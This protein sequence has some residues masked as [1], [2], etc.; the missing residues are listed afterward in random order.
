MLRGQLLIILFLAS[1]LNGLGQNEAN[2]LV[3]WLTIKE[4]QERNKLAPR[5]FLFD[6]YTDWC[7]WCKHMMKTTYSNPAIAEYV[8]QN[9]YP[10][11]F[12]AEG[13]DTIEYNG[14]VYK[15]LSK[16]PKVPHE[17]ALKMLGQQL[18]YPSTVFVT[19]NFEYTLLSQGFLEEKKIEPILVF[20]VENAW[21]TV[22][23]EEFNTNFTRT[24]Y[25]T[26]F[27]KKPVKIYAMKDLEKLQKKKPK[28]VLVSVTSS[29]CNSCKVMGKTT[30]MDS[31]I[32]KIINEKYYLV[33]FNAES[34]DTIVFK[35]EKFTKGMVNNFPLHSLPLKLAGNRFTLPMMCLLDEELNTID[36]L[37]FYYSPQ[38]IKPILMFI[39]D[40]AYK[41]KKWPDYISEYSKSNPPVK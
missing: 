31:S 39:G 32:A 27:R 11:K 33:E 34:S 13:K 35:N 40:N 20:I 15:P 9:F 1:F 16:E 29:F 30:F 6:F 37:S 41:T 21:R 18:S 4:A 23:F 22:P 8:N 2:G 25:D 7:G 24:F 38:L 19:N 3:K 10:I 12:N 36:V 26:N 14:K 28:K 5:P 17:F